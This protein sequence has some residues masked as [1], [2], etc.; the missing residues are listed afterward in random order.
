VVDESVVDALE[1]AV[2]DLDA[3]TFEGT[4]EP[5]RLVPEGVVLGG[6]DQGRGKPVECR[7]QCWCPL[8]R[9]RCS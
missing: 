9:S 7:V 1:H 5:V 3:R 2:H 6:D 8:R 4:R